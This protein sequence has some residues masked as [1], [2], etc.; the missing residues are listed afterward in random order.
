MERDDILAGVCAVVVRTL[1]RTPSEDTSAALAD[2][3]LDSL[4]SVE[5]VLS[6]EDHFGIYFDDDE[7]QFANFVS[8]DSIVALV[9]A[10]K[11]DVPEMAD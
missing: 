6:L 10:K 7:V 4:A 3:G 1:P 2:F 11:P 9:S 5:L 8:I